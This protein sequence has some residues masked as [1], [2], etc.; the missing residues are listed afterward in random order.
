METRT[1]AVDTEAAMA[2]DLPLLLDRVRRLADEQ[3]DV[4][5]ELLLARMEHAL[6]DGYAH[7][8]ALEGESLRIEREIG[9]ALEQLKS[10]GEVGKL[11][12]LADRLARTRGDLDRL[13]GVL[14]LLRRR[15]DGVRRLA[16]ESAAARAAR[17]AKSSERPAA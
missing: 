13:R 15:A 14:D 12:G 6:T 5:P 1:P 11:R 9:E 10:G 8:L 7:A 16:S 2:G 17:P 3:A 4:A